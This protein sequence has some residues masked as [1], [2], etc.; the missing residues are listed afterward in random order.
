MSLVILNVRKVVVLFAALLA[1]FIFALE[2][3]AA[4]TTEECFG[5]HDT[6]KNY[7]HGTVPCAGCHSSITSL[8]HPDKLAKPACAGCHQKMVSSFAQ[9]VHRKKGIECKECHD[10]HYLNKAKK[11]CVSCHGSVA[12]SSLPSEKKH[13]ASLTCVAC[14]GK[15]G[16]TEVEVH[17]EIKGGKALSSFAID[18]NTLIDQAQW[19]ALEDLLHTEYKGRYSIE[20]TY[21]ASGDPHTITAKPAECDACHGSA[22]HF[23]AG[24]LRITGSENLE[25]PIDT[26]I[27]IPELPS[28]KDFGKTVHGRAGVACTDCHTSQRKEADSPTEISIVC[29]KCHEDI[30]AVRRNSLHTKMGVPQCTECH[31]PHKIRSY[32]ELQAKE[33]VAVCTRCHRDYLERHR[34]LPNTSLHFDYLECATC[35]SPR[36]EKSVVFYFAQNTPTGKVRLS[37]DQL[38]ALSGEDPVGLVKKDGPDTE[39]GRLFTLL[40]RRNENLVID[41]SIVVTKPFHSYAETHLREKQ[42]IT[43]HS[44]EARFYDSMFFIL[45]GKTA[46]TYVPVRGTLLSTFPI[47]GFVDFFL[48]GEDKIMKS[49]VYALFGHGKAMDT[50]RT[51]GLGFKLIDFLG[52]LLIVLIVF[53]ISVHIILRLV[54]KR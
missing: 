43:C 38:F 32:R 53:G 47:A 3:R 39:I 20:T 37:Y 46:A 40:R 10:V 14:H 18:R 19:H 27:F 9:D 4:V 49:D 24:R 15:V 36:S 41:A 6:Y 52:L 44:G 2:S 12:H 31:N 35:H 51:P 42:C 23:T 50:R 54:V 8:P 5:C 13:L 17:L 21:Q 26:R 48:L 45:P 16:R 25:I 7:L 30:V 22:G 11:N 1:L 33:R 28:A 29:A 34:W